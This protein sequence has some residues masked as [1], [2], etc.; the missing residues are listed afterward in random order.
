MLTKNKRERENV[1]EIE[2]NHITLEL[3]TV[4]EYSR[5]L[6]VLIHIRW[7]CDA[8]RMPSTCMFKT[9]NMKACGMKQEC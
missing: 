1:K 7:W 8:E 4:I 2:R 9:S 3:L 6:T 5:M